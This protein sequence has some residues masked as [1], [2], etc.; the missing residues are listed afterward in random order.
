MSNH[1]IVHSKI[2]NN[3][4]KYTSQFTPG[5]GAD[6][7]CGTTYVYPPWLTPTYTSVLIKQVGQPT[8]GKQQNQ[9][10]TADLK[11]DTPLFP[12]RLR[13][14]TS[15]VGVPWDSSENWV[16]CSLTSPE[17]QGLPV[18]CFSALVWRSRGKTPAVSPVPV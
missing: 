4:Y 8:T 7:W 13:C 5:R 1:K 12:W 14:K 18:S 9:S 11:V 17:T 16:P 2:Y 15:G 10:S 6:S 3:Y